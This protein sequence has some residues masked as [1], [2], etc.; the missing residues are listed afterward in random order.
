MLNSNFIYRQ[1][2]NIYLSTE[3][4]QFSRKKTPRNEQCAS[5]KYANFLISPLPLTE[6]SYSENFTDGLS[7]S[8]NQS[9][10]GTYVDYARDY[11]TPNLQNTSTFLIQANMQRGETPTYV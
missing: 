2:K 10:T 6:F 8:T 11:Y 7:A 4:T 5:F 1:H 3:Q 9:I